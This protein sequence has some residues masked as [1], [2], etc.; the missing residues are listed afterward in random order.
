MTSSTLCNL[1]GIRPVSSIEHLPGVSAAND[2]PVEVTYLGKSNTAS[3]SVE[4]VTRVESEGF[5][6]RTLCRHCNSRTGGDYGTAY[7]DFIEQFAQSGV[8]EMSALRC[9]ISLQNI[10]PLRVLKQMASMFIAAQADIS[11]AHWSELRSFVR[12][13]NLRLPPDVLRFY[14]YR[15][16][17]RL[18]R[19]IPF[20][21]VASLYSRWPQL[22][23]AEISWP[24]VG[25]VYTT[26][27]HPL[28]TRMYDIT[29]WGR[30][31]H[32]RSRASFGF[33]VPQL[34]TTT[35]WPLGFGTERQAF[36]WAER[37]GV[38]VLMHTGTTSEDGAGHLP[39]LTRRLTPRPA[40]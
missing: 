9:W 36:D 20:T 6:V 21:G 7:K 1:C 24:P 3:G 14:L 35:H 26:E 39:A 31:Y 19:V 34:L 12:D 38:M 27:A 13:K 11:H 37:D 29:E 15:N 10:Q 5:V 16:T 4:H 28:V 22:F 23:M 2:R 25:I 32:F 40:T 18:G 17:S 8:F 33:S 30:D